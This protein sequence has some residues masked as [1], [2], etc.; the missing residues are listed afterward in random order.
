MTL[1]EKDRI[2]AIELKMA[3]TLGDGEIITALKTNW[4]RESQGLTIMTNSGLIEVTEG[5]LKDAFPLI[6]ESLM[7]AKNGEPSSNLFVTPSTKLQ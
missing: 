6:N 1:K 7:K 4:D 2:V 5:F 3:V